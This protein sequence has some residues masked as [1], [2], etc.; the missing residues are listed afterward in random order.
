MGVLYIDL[1]YFKAV[2]DTMG[3][4]A[5]DEVLI[6]VAARLKS[7]VGANDTVARLGGDE[8]AVIVTDV[9]EASVATALAA[10]IVEE[11]SR[12]F[13][14]KAGVANIGASVGVAIGRGEVIP[15]D[16]IVKSADQA[17]YSAKSQGRGRYEVTEVPPGGM[18]PV[19]AA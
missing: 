16:M 2:N 14:L 7:C 3:H 18:T 10:R 5:G 6:Q 15:A 17:M 1:D 9:G 4:D 13:Q 8:F 11:L 19:Q 12:P